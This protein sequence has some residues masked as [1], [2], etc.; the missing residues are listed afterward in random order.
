MLAPLTDADPRSIGPFRLS[1][2]LGA[3]GMGIV[4]LGFGPDDR[5]VAVKVPASELAGDPRFR[6]RF[7][8]EVTAVQMISSNS[9]APVVAADT[10]AETPWLATEYIQGATL[11]D[12]VH[13]RGPLAPRLMVGF[14]AGLADGLVAMHAMGVVHRD[15]KPGNVVLGWDGPK[16]IDFGVALTT[17]ALPAVGAAAGSDPDVTYARTQDGQRLG[18]FVWMAPEQLRG[19]PVGPPA[20]VFAWGACVTYATTG[21]GPF[22]ADSFAETI[23]R[24]QRDR[25]DVDDVPDQ[26]VD[27][28]LAALAKD[29]DERPTATELVSRLVHR[30]VNTPVESDRAIETALLPWV[31]QPP[32]PP[33]LGVPAPHDQATPPRRPSTSP[34][35]QSASPST[36]P[37]TPRSWPSAASTP[38]RGPWGATPPP[39]DPSIPGAETLLAPLSPPG[40][41]GP[42]RRR[43]PRDYPPA[44]DHGGDGWRGWDDEPAE[45]QTLLARTHPEA[46][47]GGRAASG[48]PPPRGG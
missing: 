26:L 35:W 40:P 6:A 16:I 36:P 33:P 13:A 2:R 28:V 25:P 32:T 44:G 47:V 4:Y 34:P 1:G 10:E 8:R 41:G 20:D 38:P 45:Q 30:A 46:A 7:R 23:A 37:S 24:I 11:T 22:R 31:A 5:P 48:P 43:P 21:H 27:L 17:R 9:V 12:A 29:P 42:P 3:G 18:T 39:D 19:G 15:L 14:A